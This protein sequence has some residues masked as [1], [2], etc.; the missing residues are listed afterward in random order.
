MGGIVGYMDGDNV[1][2]TASANRGTVHSLD[3]TG[4]TVPLV[5]QA[6]NAGGIVGKIDRSD[7][8]ELTNV[9]KN[10]Y[11]WAAVSYSYNTGDVRGY[12]GV[13]GVAGM[14]YNGEVAGSYN[15]GTVQTT[16]NAE[17]FGTG[18]Y[19]SVNM[20]GVVGDTTEGTEASA[21]LYD[22]YNKG[23]IGKY[24]ARHVGGIVGRLSGTVEKAYNTGAIYNGY[25]VVGGIVG[26]M[27]TGSI[28]NAFNTGNITVNNK[29]NGQAGIQVGGI[30]GGATAGAVTI[31]NVYNLG[32]IR[33]FQDY[34]ATADN[35]AVGGIVGA[36][37]GSGNQ[38]I[39]NAYTTGNLYLNVGGTSST[40]GLGSIYG[41]SQNYRPM[42][43]LTNTYYIRPD[44]DKNGQP[45]FTDL[46]DGTN[47]EN[48]R[49]N[50]NKAIDFAN[51]SDINEYQYGEGENHHK[52]DFT[53]ESNG[54]ISRD[55]EGNVTKDWRIYAGSTP[56][57][58]A[59]L[60]NT[61][62]YFAQNG[63]VDSN[64]QGGFTVQYGT[65]YDPLLTIIKADTAN[66]L[67][68]N[69]I[70]L[71][72]N[73]AAGIAVY[74]ADLTLKDFMSTGGSGYFGGLIYSDGALSLVAHK[75]EGSNKKGQSI[76][77]DVALGSAAEI[78]GSSV[79]IDATGDVT[80]YGDVTATGNIRDGASE[81]ENAVKEYTDHSGNIT[82]T[83]GNVDIY[84]QLTSGAVN[85][86]V[87]GIGSIAAGWTPGNVADPNEAM[88]DIGDRFGYTTSGS[89][90]DGNITITANDASD[91]HVN[92]YYH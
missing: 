74:G 53:T 58:N 9:D 23:Q 44:V 31:S 79:V 68:F 62:D 57:L 87:K 16:R 38:S 41:Y 72:A 90:V 36:F 37:I 73:N 33:G 19:Y 11:S 59:F 39:S 64:N 70:D 76:T 86:P 61:E 3:I 82:I 63:L 51:K 81:D 60:P 22:V 46:Y 18:L 15:L 8:K 55:E 21:L 84:G 26:W 48:D 12:M 10:D 30:A 17:S 47:P 66:S 91:G 54:A 67:T 56:I 83:G 6:A 50:S 2:V 40:S 80:I 77:G 1:Y 20:G 7:T 69:W 65:A 85:E 5:S 92:V 49:D 29:E 78:Y 45:L 75:G 43:T 89:A 34:G 28:T 32:T 71:G 4:T 14:M 42:M 52:L 88:S 24:Y 25:N 35:Y 13:G 27:Y